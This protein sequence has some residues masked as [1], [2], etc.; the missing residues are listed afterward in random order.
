MDFG[1][2]FFHNARRL[3]A[4]GKGPYFYLPKIENHLE[5]RLW[6][7][8]FILA[9]DLLG[10]P[11]G[12]IRATVLI[13]TITAAFEMEEIL[14]ELRDH[15]A[16]LNAGRWDY[17]F[18]LIKN[19]RTRGPRFV[20]PDR[21]QVTMTAP[22]MRAYTEQLVRACHKRGAMAIGG[23]GRR[24]FP[25]A[26]TRPPTPTP[27]RRSARTRP[28]RPP[29]A[30]TAPGWRTRTWYPCA[31]RCSTTSS[32]RGP[33]SWTA[34]ARTSLPTTA[35]SSTSPPHR[36]PSPR[37]G[38]RNNIEV[39]IRYIESWLRG[40]G[41]V[42]IHNLMEDAAT[43]EISRSQLWQWI[44]SRA[45]TDHGEII[46]R[47]WVEEMLDEEFARLERFDGDRFTDAREIFEE[48]TLSDKFPS[49]LTVP[50]YARYLHEAREGIDATAEA[51]EDELVAA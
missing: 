30:S 12:T 14:Y 45:I 15:A 46:S 44:Y 50:A 9:Q 40:N 49:F 2:Y 27:S 25:T 21:G 11:Q 29:T 5:A 38:I 34:C 8:I 24:S 7:D 18:S 3:L 47:E 51:I 4:Q 6:N 17:I 31:A 13:E 42:A 23:H 36:A 28:A 10:I 26:R 35:P 37:Q 33:T 32:G 20:L 19:F 48:V 1:L 43:A 39:G 16:G 41:A 22:F